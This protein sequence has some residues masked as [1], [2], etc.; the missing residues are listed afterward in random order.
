MT[1]ID[2]L[3]RCVLG[4]RGHFLKINGTSFEV[5]DPSGR[6]ICDRRLFLTEAHAQLVPLDKRF[7]ANPEIFGYSVRLLG[8]TLVEGSVT[9]ATAGTAAALAASIVLVWYGA[10]KLFALETVPIQENG[11]DKRLKRSRVKPRQASTSMIEVCYADDP[12]ES[13]YA[14]NA[15]NNEGKGGDDAIAANCIKQIEDAAA[16]AMVGLCAVELMGTDGSNYDAVI[17]LQAVDDSGFNG[18]QDDFLAQA[19]TYQPY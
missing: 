12:D 15:V 6:N 11:I 2:M 8:A 3:H 7:N 19:C 5:R 1:R 10:M 9:L 17:G 18:G 4:R 13:H 14:Q 16:D